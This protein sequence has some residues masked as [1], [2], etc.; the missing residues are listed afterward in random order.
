MT[1]TLS[2][3]PQTDEELEAIHMN[4]M[5]ARHAFGYDKPAQ[6][7][8]TDEVDRQK[9]FSTWAATF[10]MKGWQLWRSDAADGPQRFFAARW[11]QVRV[12]ADLEEV[13]RFAQQV[14]AKE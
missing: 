5:A 9:T 8:G 4:V 11:G 13:E 1:P 6:Q 2:P 10:A 12:L 7:A 14:G 3:P